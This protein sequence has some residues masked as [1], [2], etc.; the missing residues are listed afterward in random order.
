VLKQ[1]RPG[2][3]KPSGPQIG[4]RLIVS[5]HPERNDRRKPSAQGRDFPHKPQKKHGFSKGG[6]DE[7]DWIW[8][9]HAVEAALSNPARPAP[10]RLLATPERAKRLAPNL[11]RSDR[12]STRLN[13]SHRYISRMPSSA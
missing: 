8:G 9:I 11:T 7:K 10:K 5:S 13:S 2:S 1:R 12:K 4:A 3:R 6:N